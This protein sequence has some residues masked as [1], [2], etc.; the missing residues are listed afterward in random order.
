ME[1]TWQIFNNAGFEIRQ[2]D[3]ISVLEGAHDHEEWSLNEM[4]F[5]NSEKMILYIHAFGW[6]SIK[7]HTHV[8]PQHELKINC[9]FNKNI[10]TKNV[11]QILVVHVH[12]HFLII[13]H[14]WMIKNSIQTDFD[15]EF[16]KVYTHRSLSLF[17][18]T[19]THTH[20]HIHTRIQTYFTLIN[21]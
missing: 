5:K 21:T 1:S 19:H 6:G 20:I 14:F 12:E 7:A 16:C 9:F 8:V 10:I 3:D 18:C 4:L 15:Y 13:T 17:V 2:Y 11:P